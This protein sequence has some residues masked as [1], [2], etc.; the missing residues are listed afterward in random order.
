MNADNWPCPNTTLK[1]EKGE[2][3]H[4]H[5]GKH[6]DAQMVYEQGGNLVG[7]CPQGFSPEIALK[8]L[9]HGIPEFR[10][11]TVEA[12]YRIWSYH[13]GAIYA[14]RTEDDGKT[15]HGF[16]CGHPYEPPRSILK[17]L[18]KRA[19]DS[20]EEALIKKWLDKRWN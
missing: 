17:Q 11:T 14:A 6:A 4:K 12:P 19:R 15:W 8:L 2:N 16:P 5:S 18:E 7:K 1:Y 13:E 9:Q 20:G 3:R 10:N